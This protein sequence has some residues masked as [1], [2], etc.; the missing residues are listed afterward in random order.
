MDRDK[1]RLIKAAFEAALKP[2]AE[3]NKLAIT[4]GN[5]SFDHAT[6]RFKVEVAELGDR[7]ETPTQKTFN[8]YA[9][10]FGL[11]PEDFGVWF[12]AGGK[13]YKLVEICPNRPKYPLVGENVKTG[14]R[15]KF[16]AEIARLIRPQEQSHGSIGFD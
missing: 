16:G 10:D 9:R 4:F 3:R 15:F 12:T 2:F 7:G 14:R 1:I 13:Q 8:L 6:V 5:G 11:K